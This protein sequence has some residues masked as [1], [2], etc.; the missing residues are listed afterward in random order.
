MKLYISTPINARRE[1]TFPEKLCA[2]KHR[3]E[4]LKEI[5]HDDSRFDQFDCIAHTNFDAPVM[6]EAAAMGICVRSVL[7]SDAIYLDNGWQASKGCNLEYRAAKIYGKIIYEH[8][9]L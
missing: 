8:D 4:L 7:E 5:I 3:V 1:K 9:K 6:S 2:A